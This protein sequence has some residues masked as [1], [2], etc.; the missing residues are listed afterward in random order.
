MYKNKKRKKLYLSP[1]FF[2]CRKTQNNINF[3]QVTEDKSA[4]ARKNILGRVLTMKRKLVS[5]LLLHS[6]GSNNGSW[7]RKQ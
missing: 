5:V 2:S 6:Y 3:I 4:S 1:K 7:M